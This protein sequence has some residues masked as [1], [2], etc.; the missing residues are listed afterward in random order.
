MGNQGN[1]CATELQGVRLI[2]N[3]LIKQWLSHSE[4]LSH[5]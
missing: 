3:G 2:T 4:L 1:L 5:Q